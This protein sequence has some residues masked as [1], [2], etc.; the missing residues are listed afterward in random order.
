MCNILALSAFTGD[1]VKD[2]A[3]KSGMKD[4]FNKP[5]TKKNL[6]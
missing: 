5:L 6:I 3:I 1:N 2:Q 4:Y